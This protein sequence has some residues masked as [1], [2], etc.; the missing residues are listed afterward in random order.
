MERARY[1]VIE[2]PVGVGKSILCRHLARRLNARLVSDPSEENPFLPRFLQDRRKFA[3]QA[4]TYFL[5]RRFQQQEALKQQELFSR[6]IV[7]DY[8]FARDALFAHLTLDRDELLLYRK[9]YDLLDLQVVKPDLVVYLEIGAEALLYR[10]RRNNPKLERFLRGP[11]LEELVRSYNSFFFNY[12]ETPLLVV[13]STEIDLSG[14]E[15]DRED[16]VQ[17]ILRMG[18]GVKHFVPLRTGDP[19]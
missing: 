1:I 9:V 10:L 18:K 6:N 7:A 15:T 8:L 4:Q 2:G 16:L 13:R 11:F 19:D 17:E 3:F 14:S 12:R 5:L